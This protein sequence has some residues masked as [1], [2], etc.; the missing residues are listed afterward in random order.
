MSKKLLLLF[1]LILAACG[2]IRDPSEPLTSGIEVRVLVGPMCPVMQ[3]G[4]ECP[5]QP[6]QATLTVLNTNRK[7]V[8]QFETDE[9]GRYIVNLPPGDYILRPESPQDIP[10]SYASQQNFTILLNEIT[11]LIVVYDSGIR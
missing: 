4:V 3:A 10:L 11:Q 7:E 8:I 1:V 6:Y 2:Q 5:D 9:D